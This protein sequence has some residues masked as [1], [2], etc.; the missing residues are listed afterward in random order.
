M[1]NQLNRRAWKSIGKPRRHGCGGARRFRN[2][3]LAI[4]LCAWLWPGTSVPATAQAQTPHPTSTP[5]ATGPVVPQPLAGQQGTT[6]QSGQN[7]PAATQATV[8]LA[9][10]PA[11]VTETT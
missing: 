9:H 11:N 8:D 1:G 7:Q 2:E 10:A 4:A 5:A 6:A 3:A